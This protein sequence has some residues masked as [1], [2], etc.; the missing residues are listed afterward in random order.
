MKFFNFLDFFISGLFALGAFLFYL[1]NKD[2]LKTRR[3]KE[4]YEPMTKVESI[5]SCG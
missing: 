2:N 5:K 3:E 1:A 4:M